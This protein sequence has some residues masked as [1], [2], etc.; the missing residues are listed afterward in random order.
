MSYG[1]ETANG[2]PDVDL[3]KLLADLRPAFIGILSSYGIPPQDAED[4]VQD[5]VYSYLRKARLIENPPAWFKGALK[6]AC[7]MYRRSRGRSRV[8]AVDQAILD[9]VADESGPAQERAVERRN[10]KRWISQLDRRCREILHLRYGLG[11]EPREVAEATP[12]KPSS[13]DKV[14]RRCLD[15]LAK[16]AS[17]LVARR[18]RREEPGTD[19]SPPR[20][21][22]TR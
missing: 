20:T 7:L 6:K 22:G 16:K 8:V 2:K 17:A 15:A 5:T 11:Y 14:T 18:Q 3:G 10:L 1:H 13:I 21:T 19:E 4:L 12:Y 9:L